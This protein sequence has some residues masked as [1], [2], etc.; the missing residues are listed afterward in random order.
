[1]RKLNIAV[2][3][4]TFLGLIGCA[5]TQTQA[6]EQTQETT[7]VKQNISSKKALI[8]YY[9]ITGNTKAVARQIAASVNGDLFE[10][11]TVKKYPDEYNKLVKEVKKEI[12]ENF[13]PELKNMPKNLK[14]YDIVFIGGPNWWRTLP[15]AVSTF[16]KQNNFEGKAIVPF[17]THGGGGMQNCQKDMTAQLKDKKVTI[18]DGITFR[19]SSEGASKQDL[20][21]WLN[22]LGYTKVK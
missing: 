16:I 11:E 15:P 18:L 22:S 4:S 10:I 8:V 6:V 20:D 19:G 12:K 21:K 9:S 14:A 17:F 5:K 2:A 1:M 7:Q 3:L 13:L